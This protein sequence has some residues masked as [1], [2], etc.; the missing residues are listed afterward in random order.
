MSDVSYAVLTRA[1]AKYGKRLKENDYKNLLECD[2]IAEIM[3]YLKSNTHYIKAFGEANERDIHRG[4]FEFLLRQY[5]TYEFDTICRYELTVGEC[6]SKFITHQT[7][8]NEIVR[9]LTIL[10]SDKENRFSFTLPEHMAKNTSINLELLEEASDYQEFLAALEHSHYKFVF[11]NYKIKNGDS[12]PVSEIEDKLY[13]SLYNE[14][15]EAIKLTSGE[16]KTELLDL[17]NTILDFENFLRIIRLKKYY[18]LKP[19]LIKKHL[20]PFGSLKEKKLRDMCNA[21]S[22]AAAFSIMS[23]TKPGKLINKIDYS[24]AGGI[25]KKIQYFKAKKYMYM[26]DA[27]ATVMMSYILLSEIELMNLICII[28]GVRYNVDKEQIKSLLIY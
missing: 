16:E 22:S 15:F 2:T 13:T 14:L 7:E 17:Y 20:I 18:N 26:S 8:I 23:S 28:E 24:Y 10:S 5:I 1:K 19:E 25:P 27:P 4:L 3:T 11:E 6:F 21:E 12:I 9:V